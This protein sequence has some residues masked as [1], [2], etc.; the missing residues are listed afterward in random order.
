MTD[1][2]TVTLDLTQEQVDA[3]RDLLDTTIGDMRAE[4]ANTDNARYKSSLR[5]RQDA[6]RALRDQ[7]AS[8]TA[9]A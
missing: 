7:L 1:A 4:I 2:P 5:G 6:L 8:T 9:R 3:L